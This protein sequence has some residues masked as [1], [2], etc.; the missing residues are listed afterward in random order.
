MLCVRAVAAQSVT[1]RL[2]RLPQMPANAE[3]SGVFT[4]VK[5]VD[6]FCSISTRLYGQNSDFMGRTD[7]MGK[8]G[9]STSYPQFAGQLSTIGLLMCRTIGLYGGVL[10]PRSLLHLGLVVEQALL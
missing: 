10:A 2:S 9:R 5:K 7:F 4:E 8:P 1:V 6:K 3:I